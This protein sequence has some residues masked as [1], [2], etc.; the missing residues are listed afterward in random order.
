ME[1]TGDRFLKEEV[2]KFAK[3]VEIF[4]EML[5]GTIIQ[6]KYKNELHNI[7]RQKSKLE[8]LVSDFKPS[9]Y[10]EYSMKTKRAYEEMLYA[11]RE[12]E[13]VKKEKC[14]KEVIEEK[15]LIYK[16]KANKYEDIKEYRNKLKEVLLNEEKKN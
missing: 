2:Y 3:E 15:E 9:I 12:F 16:E 14:F 10:E 11:K 1:K 8:K 6:S 4:L 7:E 5:N 13:R